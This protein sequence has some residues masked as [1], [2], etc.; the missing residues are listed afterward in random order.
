MFKILIGLQFETSYLF[1]FPLLIGVTK[2][3]LAI[4]EN[5]F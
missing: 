2:A 5:T 4:F 3:I 1:D